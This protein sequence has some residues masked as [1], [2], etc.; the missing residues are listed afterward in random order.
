MPGTNSQKVVEM[1]LGLLLAVL[2]RL[3]QLDQATRADKGW[4]L[5]LDIIDGMVELA[6]KT[7]GL[8]GYGEVARWLSPGMQAL[9]AEVIYCRRNAS[10]E[11]EP[12][13]RK[14]VD[15][16]APGRYYLF[17]STACGRY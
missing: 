2:P 8:V 11:P 5:P 7:A 14:L 6:G 9:G 17:T 16:L 4:E 10:N 12:N 1:T 13:R 3:V 15:L